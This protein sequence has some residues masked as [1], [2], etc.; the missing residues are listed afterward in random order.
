MYVVIGVGG[1][2]FKLESTKHF[3]SKFVRLPNIFFFSSFC[4]LV[5]CHYFMVLLMSFSLTLKA[6][7]TFFPLSP[8][9]PF[10]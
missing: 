7:V 5:P 1:E 8:S 4:L 6:S 9:P 3:F 2:I 10:L